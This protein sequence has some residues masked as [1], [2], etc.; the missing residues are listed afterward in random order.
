MHIPLIIP[1][2]QLCALLVWHLQAAGH[3]PQGIT[4]LEATLNLVP[5]LPSVIVLDLDWPQGWSTAL[6]Y[7]Q[8]LPPPLLLISAHTLE[9]DIVAGLRAG[10]DDYLTKPFGLQHFLARVEALGRRYTRITPQL[11][12]GALQ[13]DLIQRQAAVAGRPL[14]LSPQ[15]FGLLCVLLQAEGR[16]LTRQ[17]ILERAWPPGSGT[18][19]TIDTHVLSLRRKL[20]E[21]GPQAPAIETIHRVGYQLNHPHL[22]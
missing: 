8:D 10:A 21:A 6:E 9:A 11:F 7:C 18:P 22:T 1:N 5:P 12:R 15:E 14:D 2:P 3:R 13:I 4:T 19:R 17:Q 20:T 16:A